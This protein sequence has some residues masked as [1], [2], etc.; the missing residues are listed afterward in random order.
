MEPRARR[1]L[2]F[3]NR[4]SNANLTFRNRKKRTY[5]QNK[6]N[7]NDAGVRR[8]KLIIVSGCTARSLH[9]FLAFRKSE[10]A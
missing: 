4:F 5:V 3:S 1:C 2:H 8:Q 7:R 10:S 9:Y 6:Y